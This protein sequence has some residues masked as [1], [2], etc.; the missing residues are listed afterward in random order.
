MMRRPSPNSAAYSS[1]SYSENRKDLQKFE[2]PG[3][4][5]KDLPKNKEEPPLV[6]A[7]PQ[8]IDFVGTGENAP[9]YVM[10]HYAF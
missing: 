2:I 7:S 8:S 9:K 10:S 6:A 3:E 4:N 1:A 5:A